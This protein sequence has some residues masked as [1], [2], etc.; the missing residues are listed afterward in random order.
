ME[1][2]NYGN[3]NIAENG[4]TLMRKAFDDKECSE[5]P[6]LATIY[7]VFHIDKEG[8]TLYA[9]MGSVDATKF[10]YHDLNPYDSKDAEIIVMQAVSDYGIE[11]CSGFGYN[12]RYP[13]TMKDLIIE[14]DTLKVWLDDIGYK[15]EID[16]ENYM[17]EFNKILDSTYPTI[18]PYVLENMPVL[19]VNGISDIPTHTN[20]H[21]YLAYTHVSENEKWYYDSSDDL[22][23]LTANANMYDKTVIENPLYNIS[24]EMIEKIMLDCMK[25]QSPLWHKKYMEKAQNIY[26]QALKAESEGRSFVVTSDAVKEIIDK[27]NAKT[28]D[29]RHN[30]NNI[31]RG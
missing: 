31:E 11:C 7:D 29:E 8:N 10:N 9:Y 17:E 12:A 20:T 26:E 28:I 1:W 25:E 15:P 23:R 14:A 16:F 21:K 30:K 24:N 27:G 2:I 18:L 6:F 13:D 5:S 22:K 4:G 3:N 19:I